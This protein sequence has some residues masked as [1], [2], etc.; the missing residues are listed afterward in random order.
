[1]MILGATYVLSLL[2]NYVAVCGFC[3][4]G[5]LIIGCFSLLFPNWSF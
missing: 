2:Y 3:A 5:C 4:V 1:M